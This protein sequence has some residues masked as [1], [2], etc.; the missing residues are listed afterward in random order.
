MKGLVEAYRALSDIYLKKSW[1]SE[2]VKRQGAAILSEKGSYR[3]VYGVVE[4]DRL[5]E[6]RI[7][8]FAEKAPKPAIKILLKMGM[9][10]LDESS[11]PPYAAVN[12]IAETAKAV[13]KG[14]VCGFLNAFL[15]RYSLEGKDCDPMDPLQLL[16]VRSNLPVWLVRRYLTELGEDEARKRLTVPRTARTHIRPSVSFGKDAL[17]ADLKERGVSCEETKYG[18][19]IGEVSAIADLLKDGKATVMSWGSMEICAAAPRPTGKILDLCAAPGGKSVLLA[20]R[21]GAEV[22]AC[23][24]YP[25]RVELI[26]KYAARMGVKGI[27]CLVADSRLLR[28]EW[29]EAFSL[30]LLDAPCSGLGSLASNPDV[31]LNRREEDLAE[32][33]KTQKELLATA[34]EYVSS[35]G[36]LLYAT[37]SD[38]PSE[39]GDVVR[40]F[41]E[42]NPDFSLEKE[43]YTDPEEGGGESY[44]YAV[45]RKR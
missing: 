7:T 16:S 6:Y 43:K 27:E 26:R 5:Y 30:V 23:D 40:S 11:L 3:L 9:Y 28:E 45:L 18:F 44:Y 8:R 32:I 17:A 36:V 39:D 35:G 13:G 42:G 37:C 4:H 14:G 22:I 15:R 20:E 25:H 33:V 12:S 24:R 29:K 38:L 10:L 34:G 1:I 21:F 31:A 41:L 2:A 19:Y